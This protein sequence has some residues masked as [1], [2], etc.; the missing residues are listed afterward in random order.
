[1]EGEIICT[2]G[3]LCG[4]VKGKGKNEEGKGKGKRKSST[5]IREERV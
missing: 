3:E 1:M 5:R 2:K 4:K